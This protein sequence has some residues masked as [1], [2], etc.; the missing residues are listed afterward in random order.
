M[1]NIGIKAFFVSWF[2][3]LSF[4]SVQYVLQSKDAN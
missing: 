1:K 3:M 4:E 2:K